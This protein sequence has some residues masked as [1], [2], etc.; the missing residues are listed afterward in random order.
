MTENMAFP[1]NDAEIETIRAIVES[2]DDPPVVMLNLNRYV[3]QA[4]YPDG[5]L[6]R[7]Y[8][9]VLEALLSRVGAAILWR[10]P[11]FGQTVGAPTMD[12]DEVL[13]VWYPSHRTF[14]ELP[15]APGAEENYRLRGLCVEKA[16]IHRCAGDREPLC[17]EP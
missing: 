13:A 12:A 3:A 16:V 5:Q 6:Y 8:M 1:R 10:A 9:S 7:N 4:G 14:L 2:G 11:V 15:N 17:R